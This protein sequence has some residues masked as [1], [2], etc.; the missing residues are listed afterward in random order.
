[1]LENF[2]YW[3]EKCLLSENAKEIGGH[4]I[5]VVGWVDDA[6]VKN[7]GYWICRNSAGPE[8][9]EEGYFRIAYGQSGVDDYYFCY[10][11]Y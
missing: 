3:L 1:M 9:G 7:G 10:G 2:P 4:W 6:K 5:V 8:W 11:V